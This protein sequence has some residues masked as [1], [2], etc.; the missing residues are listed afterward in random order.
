MWIFSYLS[1]RTQFVKYK[2]HVSCSIAVHSGVP[3][4]SHLG[5]LLF[6]MY[7]NDLPDQLR[8][9][10]I[11]LYADDAKIYKEIQTIEDCMKLQMDFNTLIL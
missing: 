2:S 3:Q 11:L 5:P 10:K 8:H 7:I 6:I 4:G 9:S 1:H